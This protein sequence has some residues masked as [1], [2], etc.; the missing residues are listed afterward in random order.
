MPVIYRR[1]PG[2][3]RRG[4]VE[5]PQAASGR[6]PDASGGTIC[7]EVKRDLALSAE[8]GAVVGALIERRPDVGVFVSAGWLSG[9]FA[10]PPPKFE[11][12]LLIF[13]QGSVIRGILP[14]AVRFTITHARVILLG[15]GMGSDRV[16]LIADRGV[17]AACADRFVAWLGESFGRRGFVLELRDVPAHSPLWGAVLRATELAPLV[18]QPREMHAL[19]YLDLAELPS[20]CGGLAPKPLAS[21]L[22]RHRRWLDRRGRLRIDVLENAADVAAAFESLVQLLRTRWSGTAQGSVPRSSPCTTIPSASAPAAPR[23]G[24]AANDSRHL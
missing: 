18:L 12:C 24:A 11:P 8:E 22:E 1:R 16:D 7:I 3:S 17:E 6:D 5:E 4:T 14:V 21:T 10:E 9:F 23:R 2:V 20:L 19:P 13:R 15:G